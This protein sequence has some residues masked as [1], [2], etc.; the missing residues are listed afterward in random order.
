MLAPTLSASL[1]GAC[2]PTR[3]GTTQTSPPTW[4]PQVKTNL[5]LAPQ[6][7]TKPQWDHPDLSA[8]LVAATPEFKL[9]AQVKTKPTS[10]PPVHASKP[11]QRDHPDLAA[12]LVAATPEFKAA[13][14]DDNGHG[15]HVAGII[16]AVSWLQLLHAH[17]WPICGPTCCLLPSRGAVRCGTVQLGELVAV[18]AV[19]PPATQL[20][21]PI[22]HVSQV[23]RLCSP[24]PCNP[25]PH[26]LTPLVAGLA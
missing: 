21:M 1:P 7:C 10:H 6:P 19:P 17:L 22:C 25:T 12:N 24:S 5:T 3:S 23:G 15:T 20:R 26:A 16:G 9:M 8:N 2:F 13:H 4:W 11:P 14:N 18:S